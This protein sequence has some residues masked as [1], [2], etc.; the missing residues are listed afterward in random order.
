VIPTSISP[1]SSRTISLGTKC[2]QRI[3]GEAFILT[4]SAVFDLPN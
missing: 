2:R 4:P 3:V 1:L